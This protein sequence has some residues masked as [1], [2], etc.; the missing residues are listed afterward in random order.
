MKPVTEP[1]TA[2]PYMI[3]GSSEP[4]RYPS[5]AE[6]QLEHAIRRAEDEGK[7]VPELRG[8]KDMGSPQVE[9]TA[10][11]LPGM[12]EVPL[13]Q[14]QCV[15]KKGGEATLESAKDVHI[16]ALI[17]DELETIIHVHG[18]FPTETD[19][20]AVIREEIEEATEDVQ[21][22]FSVHSGWW[23]RI[24]ADDFDNLDLVDKIEKSAIEG[25]KELVQV[26]ACCRKYKQGHLKDWVGSKAVRV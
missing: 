3:Q 23:L 25:I 16:E 24:R 22:A 18:L 21:E 6:E 19:A 11:V 20:W 5:Y 7:E 17:G 9:R 2:T 1:N 26:A 4:L 10:E 8:G 15:Y 12:C 13:V 14:R